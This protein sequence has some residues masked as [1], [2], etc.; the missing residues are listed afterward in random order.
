MIFEEYVFRNGTP[1]SI[2]KLLKEQGIS[3][4]DRSIS[5]LIQD[6]RYIGKFYINKRT[7]KLGTGQT[8]SQRIPLPK[9]QPATNGFQPGISDSPDPG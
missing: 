5:N 6:E 1:S 4:C 2:H 8:K 7:T 9:E 3:L